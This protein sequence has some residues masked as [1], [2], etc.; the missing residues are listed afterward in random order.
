VPIIAAARTTKE[1]DGGR[2]ATTA[3]EIEL[4]TAVTVPFIGGLFHLVEFHDTKERGYLK[5]VC[6]KSRTKMHS[7]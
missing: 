3:R 6:M 1:I 5:T 7:E 2:I 4:A